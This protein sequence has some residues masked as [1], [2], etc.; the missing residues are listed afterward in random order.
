MVNCAYRGE[1]T[2]YQKWIDTCDEAVNWLLD[3]L[4]I[5]V[6]NYSLTFNAGDF[7]EFTAAYDELSLS[8]SWNTSLNIPMATDEIA[9][10]LQEKSLLPVRKCCSTPRSSSW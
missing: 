8:R 6:E 7:P 3:Q 2:V 1:Q 9:A 5:P 4:E 10:K